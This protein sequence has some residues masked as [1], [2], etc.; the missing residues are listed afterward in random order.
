MI[1]L[2]LFLFI[3]FLVSQGYIFQ[4]FYGQNLFLLFEN[5]K[6]DNSG[7]IYLIFKLG[8]KNVLLGF[9]HSRFYLIPHTQ[10]AIL[11]II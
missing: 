3:L 9:T 6:N 8:F 5:I 2:N 10:M 11:F 1:I 7:Y 4:Y